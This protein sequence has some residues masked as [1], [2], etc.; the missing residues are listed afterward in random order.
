M[1]LRVGEQVTAVVSLGLV[2]RIHRHQ[3][4]TAFLCSTLMAR[5][6]FPQYSRRIDAEGAQVPP[7]SRGIEHL[8]RR[9]RDK[10]FIIIYIYIHAQLSVYGEHLGRDEHLHRCS[11]LP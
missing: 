1:R 4:V 7:V 8:W 5:R 9:E 11:K 3:I 6:I 10:L 2:F